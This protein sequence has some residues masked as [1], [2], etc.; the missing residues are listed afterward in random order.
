MDLSFEQE[1]EELLKKPLTEL[2][3]GFV[4]DLPEKMAKFKS[5]T[6]KQEKWLNS[7]QKKYSSAQGTGSPHAA[8]KPQ[9]SRGDV[10]PSWYLKKAIEKLTG[11]LKEEAEALLV[12]IQT[13]EKEFT[14]VK[15]I[16]YDALSG[17]TPTDETM[18][19]KDVF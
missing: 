12:R 1:I 14:R 6:E 11:P 13:G 8:T 5:L 9:S 10:P 3:R 19:L 4:T 16:V 7:I 2:E 18:D 15:K 17:K